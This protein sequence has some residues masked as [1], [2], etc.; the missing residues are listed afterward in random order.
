MATPGRGREP[1][2]MT[3]PDIVEAARDLAPVLRA[4]RI[5]TETQRSLPSPL[6]GALLD[7]QLFRLA[8]P[9]Q[10]GGVE[11]APLDALRVF[12]ELASHEAAVAWL[13]WNNTL[14]ALMSR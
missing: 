3:A 12:E 11:A 1:W 6:L 10:D 9:Q 13:V 7:A 8:I 14:P 5:E 4:A 2:C